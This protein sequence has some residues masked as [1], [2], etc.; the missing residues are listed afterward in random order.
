MHSFYGSGV[1]TQFGWILCPRSH[2]AVVKELAE[3][4]HLKLG[5][6]FQALEVVGRIQSL[7]T[8]ELM[9]AFFSSRPAGKEG[10]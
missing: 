6:L 7:V 4:S 5:V 1:Q 8:V 2:K 10:L 3:A 9:V